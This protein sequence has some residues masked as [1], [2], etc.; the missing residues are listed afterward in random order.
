VLKGIK[1]N[2]DRWDKPGHLP[3]KT[4][5]FLFHKELERTGTTGTGVCEEKERI[6]K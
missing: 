3:V 2:R 4:V 6:K 5:N 1:R